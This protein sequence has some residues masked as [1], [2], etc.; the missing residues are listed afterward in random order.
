MNKQSL[1]QKLDYIP[2]VIL[3]ISAII[4]II[5][6]IANK[7]GLL[8]K[9]YLGFIGLIFIMLAFF[10]N[11]KTGVI[12]IGLVLLLGL[13]GLL[14]FSAAITIT[15]FNIGKPEFS[16]PIFYGQSIYLLWI[17]IHLVI[18]GRYYFGIGTKKYWQ[19]FIA[20]KDE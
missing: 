11:H 1:R 8:W 6:V 12:T 14:S 16:I 5:K 10:R 17:S 9:H 2:F 7:N 18:S 13:F 3:I 20:Q 4:L 19:D 15:T